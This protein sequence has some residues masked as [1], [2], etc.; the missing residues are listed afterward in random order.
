[1]SNIYIQEP[2]TEGKVLLKTTVGDIEIELFSREC[3]RAC[4]RFVQLCLDGFYDGLTFH[5]LDKEF[6][7]QGGDPA[8]NGSGGHLP[9]DPI[10]LESHSRLRFIRR[11]LVGLADCD[12][13]QFFFT[14]GP[15]PELQD[16]H[17]LFGKVLNRLKF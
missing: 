14:L 1:M 4:K 17:T 13:S 9:E 16:K 10:R 15:T 3:P 2:S 7:V 6:I 8:G 12:S 5:R 11:G